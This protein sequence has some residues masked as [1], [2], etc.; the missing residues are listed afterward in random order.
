MVISELAG[1]IPPSGYCQYIPP[2]DAGSCHFVR[3]GPPAL[4][5]HLLQSVLNADLPEHV[6]CCYSLSVLESS[7]SCILSLHIRWHVAGLSFEN[8]MGRSW[9]NSREQRFPKTQGNLVVEWGFRCY[10]EKSHSWLEDKWQISIELWHLVKKV[11]C[12]VKERRNLL[13]VWLIYDKSDTDYLW[14]QSLQCSLPRVWN[15]ASG[16]QA[17][18]LVIQPLQTVAEDLFGQWD[19]S[20]VWILL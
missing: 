16:P 10:K 1:R 20:V 18:G 17:A 2:R 6:S 9:K 7:V 12:L 5:P 11:I 14:W 13:I 15:C 3:H 19:Q 8:L 4:P